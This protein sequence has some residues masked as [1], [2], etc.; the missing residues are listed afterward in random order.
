MTHISKDQKVQNTEVMV[1]YRGACLGPWSMLLLTQ[2]SMIVAALHRSILLSEIP[3]LF[4]RLWKGYDTRA[5][6]PLSYLEEETGVHMGV[7][8][9]F[10]LMYM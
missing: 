4:P 7:M 8:L 10:V 3:D 5:Q 9:Y 1:R 6:A 2:S